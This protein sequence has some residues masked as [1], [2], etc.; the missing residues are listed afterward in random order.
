MSVEIIQP[1]TEEHWLELRK[2]D[3]TST[4]IS[5]LFG[6]S[7]YMTEF[8]LWHMKKTGDCLKLDET[9][10]MF[11]GKKLQ[12][13]IAQGVAEKM[14][15]TV[16]RMD[17]YMRDPELRIGASFD[18]LIKETGF[19]LE[20]KNVDY[21]QFKKEWLENEDGSIEAPLHIELQV[22]H[23]MTVAGVS[24]AYIAVLVGGNDVKIIKR[25]ANKAIQEKIREKVSLFWNSI[26]ENVQPNPD[27][28]RDA[29]FV[30]K[31]YGHAEPGTVFN[32]IG[33]DHL[34]SLMVQY[35]AHKAIIKDLDGKCE[36]IKAEVLTI[37]GDAEKVLG[38]GYTISAGVI[39]PAEISYTRQGYRTFKPNTNKL[40]A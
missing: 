24:T 28:T 25:N 37:I 40:E 18:F 15:W 5:A 34:R 1:K 6:I 11:W 38:D 29:E 9:D 32:A 31:L 17:E 20:I 14:G 16:R 7:P 33:N 21:I 4:E 19:I 36:A 30:A 2:S 12:D 22:Q 10:R 27:F 35:K 13:S 39:G 26:E 3:I 8:E 23:Q